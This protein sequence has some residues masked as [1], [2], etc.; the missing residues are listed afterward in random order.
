MLTKESHF[1]LMDIYYSNTP[2]MMSDNFF[3]QSLSV[4]DLD[5]EFAKEAWLAER[6]PDFKHIWTELK[7]IPRIKTISI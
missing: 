6:A 3:P 5:W 7:E 4:H 2:G 1:E